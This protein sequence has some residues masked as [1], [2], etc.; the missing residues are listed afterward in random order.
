MAE[1]NPDPVPQVPPLARL[2]DRGY[3]VLCTSHGGAI[4]GSDFPE[5]LADI[6]AILAGFTIN[7]EEIVRG[8]G[9]E[10][11]FTQRLRRAFVDRG[12]TLRQF[13]VQK[14]IDGVETQATSHKVDHVKR[15]DKGTVALEIEWNDKT[16][17]RQIARPYC[18]PPRKTM[19]P[20]SRRT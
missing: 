18:P 16:D 13:V 6:E 9:G 1:V 20:K 11:P 12:W 2:R 19:I 5:A 17:L 10:T 8:G 14:V 15:F 7:V 4:L 3:N